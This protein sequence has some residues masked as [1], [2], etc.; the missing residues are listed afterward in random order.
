[1]TIGKEKRR[2]T[3]KPKSNNLEKEIVKI[4]QK[5]MRAVLDQALDD[6]FKDTV[7]MQKK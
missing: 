3:Q 4:M 2:K 5:S 6:I 7:F 1:M